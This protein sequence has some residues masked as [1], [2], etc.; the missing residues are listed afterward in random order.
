MSNIEFEADNMNFN[1][2]GSQT[3]K[4]ISKTATFLINKKIVKTENQANL[5]ILISV[6][7]IIAV[8]IFVY[9]NFNYQAPLITPEQLIQLKTI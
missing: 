8:S 9:R 7:V 6:A 2:S 5:L 4:R 1:K 3:S